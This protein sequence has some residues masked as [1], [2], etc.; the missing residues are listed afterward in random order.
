[1]NGTQRVIANDKLIFLPEDPASL[2]F[3]AW[4]LTATALELVNSAQSEM[5]FSE[6]AGIVGVVIKEGPPF[7]QFTFVDACG[8]PVLEDPNLLLVADVA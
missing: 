1:G 8:M 5:S 4:G 6:G 2:G 3:T 7:R